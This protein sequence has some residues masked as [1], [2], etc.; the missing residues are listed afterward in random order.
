MFDKTRLPY[1]ALD[2]LC[3]LLGTLCRRPEGRARAN[4]GWSAPVGAGVCP[5]GGYSRPAADWRGGCV[6]LTRA[7]FRAR[8][9]GR[10]PQPGDPALQPAPWLPRG[11]C[12]LF[13]ARPL[14]T[15]ALNPFCLDAVHASALSPLLL[16]S[17][18]R[19]TLSKAGWAPPLSLGK[20][21][22][23]LIRFSSETG[24]LIH[25]GVLS[26]R[27][28]CLVYLTCGKQF[29]FSSIKG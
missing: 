18:S 6:C 15:G 5:L 8:R 21:G 20:P 29:N 7:P 4:P 22:R 25:A 1:V 28:Q 24:G 19:S 2:V 13:V 27:R 17:V 9:G 23:W 16:S 11:C 12:C 26:N 10:L 3:L 14:P